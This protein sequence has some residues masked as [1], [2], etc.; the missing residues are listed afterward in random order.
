MADEAYRHAKPLGGWAGLH[1]TLTAAGCAP[2]TPGSVD[3]KNPQTVLKAVIK[4]LGHH[5]VW[6]RF[7][8]AES[9]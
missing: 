9:V 4:L 6:D 8:A 1:D 3:G 5:R 2:D 7:P